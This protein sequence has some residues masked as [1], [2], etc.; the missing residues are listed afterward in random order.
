MTLPEYKD[1]TL[2]CSITPSLENLR[3]KSAIVTGGSSGLG[4]AFVRRLVEAGAYVTFGDVNEETGS[5]LAAELAGQARF[6]RCDVRSWEEQVCL[7]ESAVTNSPSNTCD[8][9]IANAGIPG[10]DGLFTD[11]DLSLPPTK[12]D[13][14][15]FDINLAG[16]LYT[17]KLALHYFR[18]QPLGPARDRCLI[19]ISSIAGYLDLPGSATYSMSKFGVRAL[20]RSLRRNAWVDSIRVNL[21][22]PGYIITPAY[23]EEIIAFFKSKGVEFASEDDACKAVMRIASDTTVNG[24][25]LAVVPR[26]DCAEGYFDLTQDDFPEGSKLH[27]LQDISINVGS[28]T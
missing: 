12:P 13:T 15:I 11:E 9:V 3:G 28:R 5:K 17:T 19:L 7:F 20:M 16:T 6:V 22:A 10:P 14:T 24:R 18:R 25:S 21:V 27:A 2:D 4:R 26:V 1:H 23:T 8:I